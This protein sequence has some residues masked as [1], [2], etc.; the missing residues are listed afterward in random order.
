M[1]FFFWKNSNS[2]KRK[3]NKIKIE[4]LQKS[5]LK[6]E[7][8]KNVLESKIEKNLTDYNQWMEKGVKSNTE[9]SLDIAASRMA[10]AQGNMDLLTEDLAKIINE[11]SIVKAAIEIKQ[12]DK[13]LD[14]IKPAKIYDVGIF[15]ELLE[16]INRCMTDKEFKPIYDEI[17][18]LMNEYDTNH[19]TSAAIRIGRSL[20]YLI[21]NLAKS[22]KVDINKKVHQSIV[23]INQKTNEINE[24]L[25]KLNYE[26]S[27]RKQRQKDK[28]VTLIQSLNNEITKLTA[29]VDDKV[30]VKT[31]GPINPNAI[32][33]DIKKKYSSNSKIREDIDYL[34]DEKLQILSSITE[35]RN[36][37]A[38]FRYD[39]NKTELDKEEIDNMLVTLKIIILR[40]ES[41]AMNAYS[42]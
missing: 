40:L 41:V 12:S 38:H 22:L 42:Y 1:G 19:Y 32:L 15:D 31:S 7:T 23:R 20:E 18:A 33:R 11:M 26:T 2:F 10:I 8:D 5:Y 25:I 21:Y 9:Q 4:E 30:E 13:D 16:V 35:K 14:L 6:L 29:N 17:K 28:V 37:A 39:N 34:L 27:E 3:F 24:N 36:K